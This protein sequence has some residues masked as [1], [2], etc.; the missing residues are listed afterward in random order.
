MRHVTWSKIFINIPCVYN[1][2]DIIKET[3]RKY[4]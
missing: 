2:F 3:R 4:D 1:A